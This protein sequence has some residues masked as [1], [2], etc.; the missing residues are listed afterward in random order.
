MN[1]RPVAVDR[2]INDQ[3]KDEDSKLQ[4]ISERVAHLNNRFLAKWNLSSMLHLG[5]R[6]FAK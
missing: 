6:T 5:V 2:T 3:Y 1:Y 4:K